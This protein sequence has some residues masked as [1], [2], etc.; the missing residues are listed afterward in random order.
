MHSI[1]GFLLVLAATTVAQYDF[2]FTK[3]ESYVDPGWK[4]GPASL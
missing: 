3:F 2:N 1:F 4:G